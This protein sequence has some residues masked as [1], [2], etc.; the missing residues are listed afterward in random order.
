MADVATAVAAPVG[1]ELT[2]D[3]GH[4]KLEALLPGYAHAD[5]AAGWGAPRTLPTGDGGEDQ[6]VSHE[7][8]LPTPS[9]KVQLTNTY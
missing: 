5:K 8:T 2:K 3:G 7:P 4:S 9:K 6:C 1:M